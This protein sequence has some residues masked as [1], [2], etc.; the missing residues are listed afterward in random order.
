MDT[1]ISM[2][3]LER[4]AIPIIAFVLIFL[5]KKSNPSRFSRAAMKLL[6]WCSLVAVFA[7]L[8]LGGFA[9]TA[10]I[11]IYRQ[12]QH[13][14]MGEW[15]TKRNIIKQVDSTLGTITPQQAA[16]VLREFIPASRPKLA[17]MSGEQVIAYLKKELPDISA[18]AEET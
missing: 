2:Q 4:S 10:S 9:V 1:Q 11:R 16:L 7:Y 13:A 3:I 5:D 18:Q 8:A 17:S 14:N 15:I 12:N 6:S